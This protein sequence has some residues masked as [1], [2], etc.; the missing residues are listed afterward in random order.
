M[1]SYEARLQAVIVAAVALSPRF[2]LLLP[3]VR[4]AFLD[5]HHYSLSNA[6]TCCTKLMVC[7]VC[8]FKDCNNCV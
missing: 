7:S 4:F 6:F 3:F 5:Q 8:E 2:P 1:Q